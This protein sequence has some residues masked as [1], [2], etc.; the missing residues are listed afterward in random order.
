MLYGAHRLSSLDMT[1]HEIVEALCDVAMAIANTDRCQ[2]ECSSE[3]HR[4]PCIAHTSGTLHAHHYPK[5]LPHP[6]KVAFW[7][8][9][10]RESFLQ[11]S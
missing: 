4:F 6:V 11:S 1:T 3:S 7:L 8:L 5:A 2:A 9:K 10:D